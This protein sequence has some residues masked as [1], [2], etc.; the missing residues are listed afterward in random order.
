MNVLGVR[1]KKMLLATVRYESINDQKK[2]EV[3]WDG[4][5]ITPAAKII[6]WNNW[7]MTKLEITFKA[8]TSHK[9]PHSLNAHPWVR[10]WWRGSRDKKVHSWLCTTS[11]QHEGH[12]GSIM[13]EWWKKW[14]AFQPKGKRHKFHWGVPMAKT[15]LETWSITWIEDETESRL[16][17]GMQ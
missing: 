5:W 10:R 3:E 16:F 4:E 8:K 1:S 11:V 7:N 15:Y 6:Y 13:Q 9:C 2:Q 17:C 12:G 14:K